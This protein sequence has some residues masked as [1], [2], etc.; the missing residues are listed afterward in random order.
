MLIILLQAIKLLRFKMW[1]F[2]ELGKTV[3]ELRDIYYSPGPG[4]LLLVSNP[5]L[6]D[7]LN[8]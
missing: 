7:L 5:N 3:A 2:G 6:F 4:V 1:S 8:L